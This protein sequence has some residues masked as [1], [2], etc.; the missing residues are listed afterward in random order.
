MGFFEHFENNI[1]GYS[2]VIE[3]NQSTESVIF[4]PDKKSAIYIYLDFYNPALRREFISSFL[5]TFFPAD[6]KKVKR[7]KSP[8]YDEYLQ[9]FEGEYS[10][11]QISSNNISKF[12]MYSSSIK[13]KQDNKMLLLESGKIDPYGDLEGQLQFIEIDPFLFRCLDREAYISFKM[14]EAGD[15]AYLLSG[16][17]QHGVY[18]KLALHET[19]VFHE[20]F[21]FFFL[22][23]YS[24]MLFLLII[25][26]PYTFAK[27]IA[28]VPNRMR[29]NMHIILWLETILAIVIFGCFY[30]FIVYYKLIDSF[31]YI[32]ER[33]PY[34]YTIFSL[35]FLFVLGIS[36]FT[37]YSLKSFFERGLHLY[38]Q[39]QSILFLTVS[40]GFIYWLSYWN[41]LSF[42][43]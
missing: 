14:D 41:L 20:N 7:D 38:R 39:I 4:F 33:N 30:Y 11:V 29:R 12:R 8:G 5:D 15:V 22:S 1:W 16:S 34:D 37:Y 23:F 10:A 25:E 3:T 19:K 42:A 43:F 2:R 36:V 9:N 27:K 24:I 31:E 35:P 18:R 28:Y 26:I 6:K 21:G 13:I 17:G 40:L 32:I